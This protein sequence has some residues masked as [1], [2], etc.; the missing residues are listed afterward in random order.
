[1][2]MTASVPLTRILARF[3]AETRSEEIPAPVF[4]HAK[5]A[6][7]DWL[8][9]TLAGKDDPLV[10]KLLHHADR[11]GGREQA[12]IL[13]H[14]TR[15]S[16]T[17]AALV[18]GAASHALDFDDTLRLF[19]GHPT[20]TILPGLVA[21][22]EWHRRP[23]AEVLT[24]FI[25]G[26]QAGAAVG[27]CA[28]MEHYMSGW[29]ATATIGHLASAAAC[30][31]LLGL[32]A[33]QTVHALGIAGT[34][35]SGVKRVFGT[36][37]K[38]F[39]AGMASEA[40]L[41]A[42]LLAG[43]GFTSAEDILEGP[44]GFF[45][46]MK[47]QVNEKVV[48]ALGKVWSI[49]DLAQKYHASCHATHSPIEAVLSVLEKEAIAPEGIQ[50]IRIV[51]SQLSADAAGK[52]APA[53]GLEGKFSIPYCVAN[54]VLR[55]STGA[56]A[57]TDEKVA[58]PSVR[59]LM[60]KISVSVSKEMEALEANVEIDVSGGTRTAYFDILKDIPPLE[61]KRAKVREKFLDL[62]APVLGA[63]KAEAM[64]ARILD[65]GSVEDMGLLVREVG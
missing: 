42:A 46:V 15:K 10:G 20:V 56:Q 13:G 40:G 47:G 25:L 29:H 54:A 23:G 4:D 31:R 21:L 9:V 30:S 14:G 63:A 26:M 51:V 43:D 3:V 12:T 64:A 19:L 11:L 35:A 24:A 37:C 5:V 38:P 62:C 33:G 8:A 44:H 32:D 52:T 61:V 7:L 18:N 55:G 48:G 50:A 16:V 60:G 58:D 65:L 34:Q 6:L 1:M 36:M 41:T 57:F 45:A 28:G 27:A 22:A 39:H 2:E 59:G 49:Q 53:T 17:Q